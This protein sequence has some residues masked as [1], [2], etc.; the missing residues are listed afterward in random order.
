M[1]E[2]GEEGEGGEEAD[3]P[4]WV[5]A[6]AGSLVLDMALNPQNAFLHSRKE[7]GSGELTGNLTKC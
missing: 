1:R 4:I 6:L 7:L 5:R 3:L 2:G